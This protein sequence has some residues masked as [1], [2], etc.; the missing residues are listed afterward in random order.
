MLSLSGFDRFWQ[1][2]DSAE[3]ALSWTQQSLAAPRSA[4]IH[5]PFCQR[6]CFYCD[7]PISVI[8]HRKHGDNSPSIE[9]YVNLLC[10]EIAATPSFNQSLETIFL[11]G[12]TPSLLSVSQLERILDEIDRRLGI[13]KDAEI[14]MEMD[15]GTFDRAKLRG[16]LNSGIDRVSFGAQAFQDELLNVCGRSHTVAD[17][18]TAFNLLETEGVENVSFDLMSGLPYQTHQQWKASLDAALALNP[19][20]LSL[21]DLIVEPK[22]VFARFYRP[23][24]A[25]FPE[26]EA[27]ADW[28]RLAR[29]S[30][31]DAGY[32]HYEISNYARPGFECRHN[33]TYWHNQP[34]YGFGLGATSYVGRVRFSRPRTRVDYAS[35]V[36]Q[37]VKSGGSIDGDPVSDVDLVLETFMLGFRLAT[38]LSIDTL[39]YNLKPKIFERFLRSIEP[40]MRKGWIEVNEKDRHV[41]LSDPEGFLFSNVVLADLFEQFDD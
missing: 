32:A 26:A 25:P 1:D 15:P 40:Y 21:Y 9:Q 29:Q 17:I 27:A 33:L 20:H 10:S 38:G 28:Y 34:Y 23:E 14:S 31:V 37:Y 5:V 22:T 16:F 2:G 3:N 39:Q 6:R 18:Y 41:R 13:A 8:G 7:F 30:L 35:W 24:T 36:K 19:V 12:G 4:Y 11:G